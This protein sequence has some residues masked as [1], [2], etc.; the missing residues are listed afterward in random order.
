M[1]W[2][3]EQIKQGRKGYLSLE[4]E[5]QEQIENAGFKLDYLQVCR[6]DTL[7]AAG[8]DDLELTV[9]GAMYTESARLID[10]ISVD[11]NK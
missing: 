8:I 7:I 10:N 9:L 3:A 5:A 11:L 6:S 2:V 4:R 1:S